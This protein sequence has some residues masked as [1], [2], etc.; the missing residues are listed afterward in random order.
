[1]CSVFSPNWW[2]RRATAQVSSLSDQIQRWLTIMLALINLWRA[3]QPNNKHLYTESKT[4][5]RTI[6]QQ[7]SSD[8]S[9][10]EY[11]QLFGA[12]LD[13]LRMHKFLW[14][15]PRLVPESRFQIVN[16]KEFIWNNSVEIISMIVSE[17][18]SHP[19]HCLQPPSSSWT[20]SYCYNF[21]SFW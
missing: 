15:E 3:N 6:F 13:G 21:C 7:R 8:Q 1:M 14:V 9:L 10:I 2:F 17:W 20:R 11:I 12:M 18:V 4:S 5:G 16:Q 19:L